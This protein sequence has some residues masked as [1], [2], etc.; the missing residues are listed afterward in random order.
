MA[1]AWGRIHVNESDLAPGDVLFRR[2]RSLVSR[3]VLAVDG[4][5][6]YSH[7]G[8]VA[9]AAGRAWVLHATPPEQPDIAGGVIAEPLALF[10][11]TDRASAAAVYRPR[12]R[13]AARA[14]ERVAWGY[15]RGHLRFD[16]DFDL[17]SS[18][19]LYCTELVWKAYLSAGVDL[20]AGV[21]GPRGRYLL[22]GRLEESPQ[23][24]RFRVFQ[25]EVGYP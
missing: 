9:L 13:Q 22:P 19:R 2:G 5:G 10:L 25:E 23:L 1:R 17:V 15:V 7:V 3:A 6:E 4:H 16:D 21:P 11:A 18:D 8:L 24:E 14:A 12:D 20:E